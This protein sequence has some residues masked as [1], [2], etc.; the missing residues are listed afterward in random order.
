VT[1][2]NETLNRFKEQLSRSLE[3]SLGVQIKPNRGTYHKPYP[4][5]FDFLKAPDVEGPNLYKFSGDDSR[6]S[7]EHISMFLAQM[8]EASTMDFMNVRHF[9]LSLTGTAFAWF[10][11]L[12][13]CSIG[14]WAELEEKFHDHFYNGVHETRLFHLTSIRQERD[15]SILD[16]VKCFRDIKNRCFHLM[17]SKRDL[18]D[19]CFAGLCPN[20]R[21]KL[22]H[23]EFVNVNQLLQKAVSVE[24]PSKSLVIL[25]G[26]IVRMCML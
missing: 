3:S 11:S 17:I 12:A 14:S 21:E 16:F 24:S 25:I 19:L 7:M 1:D 20:I 9:P 2:F 26:H 6:S 4:S 18:T 8:G 13:S 15:E 23:Y 10:T 22:E 5:H